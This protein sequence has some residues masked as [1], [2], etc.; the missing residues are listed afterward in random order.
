MRR[1]CAPCGCC[2]SA[3]SFT[4]ISRGASGS[5]AR[6]WSR[7]QDALGAPLREAYHVGFTYA[8][9]WVDDSRLVVLNALDA[10]E[11]GATISVGARLFSAARRGT[12]GARRCADGETI[13]ARAL[14]NAAGP[15]VSQV[16]E[17]ALPSRS[18]KH[19]RLVKG[20]HLVMRKLYDGAHAYIL[21]N[22]DGRIVFAIPYEHDFT[23]D[24]HDG[25]LL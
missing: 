12:A 18:R 6:I 15:W 21:Q 3:F 7:S 10:K 19:V 5:K 1:A 8:D 25:R 23:L 14:V 16:I 13:E 9:C 22:P 11:R 2:V 24:R 20:S 4:T 17:D